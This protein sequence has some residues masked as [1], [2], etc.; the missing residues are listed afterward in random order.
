[1]KKVLVVADE[2]GWAFD[3]IYKGLKA[4]C[5][6]YEINVLYLNDS[7]DVN[8]DIMS[9]DAVLYLCDNYPLPLIEWVNRGLSKEKVILAVR[10]DVK[11]PLYESKSLLDQVCSALVVSNEAQF[12]RFKDMHKYVSIASGGVDTEK[13]AY[14]ERK[15][16]EL[17]NF[18]VG[19]AG[20]I[21]VFDAKFRGLDIIQQACDE[22]GIVFKP[23][24][25]QERKRTEDEM[26]KYYHDEINLYIDMS[27]TAGRQNGLVE[28]G[29][30]GLPIISYNA[31]I[32]EEMIRDD[33]CG[34]VVNERTVEAVKTAIMKI[35]IEYEKYSKAIR[36]EIWDFWSWQTQYL[37][38]F[39]VID[40]IVEKNL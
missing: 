28:A 12:E 26:V 15:D 5:S 40:D 19:W 36:N 18:I 2:R 37:C 29:S 35:A 38:F 6:L 33:E 17:K 4:N 30:T 34:V 13:F 27:E 8:H 1:M 20:S 10:S 39:S 22:L 24:L 32:A 14:K 9:Y 31:G 21:G 16:P 23:A 11:H 3:K 25:A 7:N